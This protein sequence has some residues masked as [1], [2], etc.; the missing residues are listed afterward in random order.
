MTTST[1]T[2]PRALIIGGSLGGLF[3]ATTLQAI[4]WQVDIFERSPH[5]LD[6]RG[7][8]VVLQGDVLRAFNFAGIETPGA[9]GVQ[10][11][12]RIYLDREDKVVSRTFMPQTQTSWN[13][14]YGAMKRKL[15]PEVFHPGEQFVRFEQEGE[16]ITAHFASGRVETGDLLVGADGARSAVRQQVI[17]GL[18]PNY[19]GY[20]AWRGLVEEKDL[21][22]RAADVLMGTF[23]FQQGP[24][25]LMLEYLVP[26]E[27]E[28][29][30]KGHRRWNW[31]WYQKVAHGAELAALLTDRH[32]VR[33]AFSL[34]PGTPK[35]QDIA[36]LLQTSR[37]LLAPTFQDLVAATKEPFV[38]AIL[39]LQVEQMVF[40]RAILV[41][42]AAFVPRPHT[43][44]STAKAAANA[45]SLA[46]ALH[47]M[48]SGIDE[49]L[50]DWQTRQLRDGIGMTE[51]G[52]NIGDRIMGISRSTV[53]LQSA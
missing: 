6:S 32:G 29:T 50:A 45:L 48:G 4:G 12:D 44:G 3:T 30:Q 1:K 46:K 21:P 31:V 37:G 5:V 42:D 47:P 26:G 18:G 41:G 27:D 38:Q 13:M 19:G 28:S 40:G 34:P 51:W 11:G 20:V 23:A 10:S 52:M 24:G 49:A 35:D 25:H 53:K 14:L 15:P 22:K 7:G 33:H 39:D 43:A 2:K 17:P 36:K 8:G 16:R 9:L